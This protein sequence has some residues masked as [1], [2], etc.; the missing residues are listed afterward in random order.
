[1]LLQYDSWLKYN[2]ITLNSAG[3]RAMVLFIEMTNE[4][5]LTQKNKKALP[6]THGPCPYEK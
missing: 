3:T 2:K 6:E 1:M 5:S 4:A